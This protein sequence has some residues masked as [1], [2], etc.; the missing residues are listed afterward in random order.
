MVERGGGHGGYAGGQLE[1]VRFEVG[2]ARSDGGTR[3]ANL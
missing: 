1:E 2:E 3:G